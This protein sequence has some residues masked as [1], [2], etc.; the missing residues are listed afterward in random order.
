MYLAYLPMFIPLIGV[1]VTTLLFIQWLI[2]AAD[3]EELKVT[4]AKPIVVRPKPRK[5]TPISSLKE[6]GTK[7]SK[8]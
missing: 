8:N 4:K 1:I 3:E 7:I 5:L 2:W 6:L